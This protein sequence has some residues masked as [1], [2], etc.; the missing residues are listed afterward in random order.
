MPTAATHTI[1]FIP[2]NSNDRHS[3]GRYMEAVHHSALRH[4]Q[5]D[6]QRYT[7]E[8]NTRA[9]QHTLGLIMQHAASLYEYYKMERP[10]AVERAVKQAAETRAVCSIIQVGGRY[11][12][13]Q[14]QVGD[15]ELAT[16]VATVWPDGNVEWAKHIRA[17]TV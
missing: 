14:H 10:E 9:Q 2:F 4:L 8:C 11:H 1:T 15:E 7:K 3:D 16:H 5:E 17:V 6:L 12:V 13:R